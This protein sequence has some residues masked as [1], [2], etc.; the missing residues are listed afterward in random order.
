MQI[1]FGRF[2]KFIGCTGYPECKGIKPL[3]KPVPTGVACGT[4]QQGEFLERRSRRGK[5]F[6]SCSR[7][8]ECTA[9][10]WDKPIPEPCPSCG[11]TFITEKVTKRYGTVRRCAGEECAWQVQVE[12]ED[13][14]FAPLPERRA[15]AQVRR[16]TGSRAKPAAAKASK[17]AKSPATRA[18]A[19]TPAKKTGAK[20]SK[21]KK[22]GTTTTPGRRGSAGTS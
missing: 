3:H 4:C 11:A 7:Y 18:K 10:A 8:P 9:V 19:R 22:A 14:G 1:R 6:Y 21:R 12:G 15:A 17:A 16:R 20:S 13:A 5:T 2:G